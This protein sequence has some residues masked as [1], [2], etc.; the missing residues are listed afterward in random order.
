MDVGECYKFDSNRIVGFADDGTPLYSLPVR[1]LMTVWGRIRF[2]GQLDHSLS[3]FRNGLRIKNI[4]ALQ[5]GAEPR[6]EFV[7]EERRPGDGDYIYI[8]FN[9]DGIRQIQEYVYAPEIDTA[10]YVRIQLLI[11]R[12]YRLIRVLGVR[13]SVWTWVGFWP[14][15][16]TSQHWRNFRLNRY[17]RFISKINEDAPLRFDPVGFRDQT[18]RL[19]SYQKSI[20]EQLFFNRANPNYASWA[21]I[22]LTRPAKYSCCRGLRPGIAA[23]LTWRQDGVW[24][25]RST[26]RRRWGFQQDQRLTNSY[27]QQNYRIASRTSIFPQH[28]ELTAICERSGMEMEAIRRAG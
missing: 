28:G 17:L 2:I 26:V 13:S 11:Q 19:I 5:S 1:K 15:K 20:N 27:S 21:S 18:G 22:I 7:Y 24:D 8:D 16:R 25:R 14:T 10:R 3:R 23:T 4:Y 12:M 9:H 6:T